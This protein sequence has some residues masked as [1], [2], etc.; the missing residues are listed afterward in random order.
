MKK[1]ADHVPLHAA[2]GEALSARVPQSHLGAAD[3]S[4]VAGVIRRYCWGALTLPEAQRRVK[5]RRPLFFGLGPQ[6]K[7]RPG[8]PSTP[9][10]EGRDAA[11]EASA[12]VEEP[13][14]GVAVGGGD[15]GA[16]GAPSQAAA[17]AQGGPRPGT[18][19]LG[20]AASLGAERVACRQEEL[21][22]G[23]RCPGWGHGP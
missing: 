12:P 5:R 6:G 2:A 18:G 23:Q 9:A 22:G 16:E 8:P 11:R 1:P 3:A 13:T 21:A 20:P 7:R 19:R 15:E 17:R 14:A 4:G 10:P